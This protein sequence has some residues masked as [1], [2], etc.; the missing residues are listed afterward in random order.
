MF[1]SSLPADNEAVNKEES[2]KPKQNKVVILIAIAIVSFIIIVIASIMIFTK[3]RVPEN[4]SPYCML[5]KSEGK[6]CKIHNQKHEGSNLSALVI[7]EEEMALHQQLFE[8]ISNGAYFDGKKLYRKEDEGEIIA[9][10]NNFLEEKQTLFEKYLSDTLDEKGT[11]RYNFIIEELSTL[12]EVIS[13]LNIRLTSKDMPSREDLTKEVEYLRT[14]LEKTKTSQFDQTFG[15]S[16]ASTEKSDTADK[17]SIESVKEVP[18]KSEKE[19]LLET[20]T[21]LYAAS[22]GR[23]V[24]IPKDIENAAT[25]KK[26]SIYK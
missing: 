18:K 19:K 5:M 26:S 16:D 11:E 1:F 25:I 13:K 2:I 21:L 17:P 9:I 22:G 6:I 12:E 10:Y 3:L 24:D 23:V 20:D 7:S 15:S 8:E 4:A 14:E